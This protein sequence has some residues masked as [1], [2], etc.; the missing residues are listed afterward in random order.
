MKSNNEVIKTNH[1]YKNPF[2][3]SSVGYTSAKLSK[4]MELSDALNT[5]FQKIKG[6][7]SAIHTIKNSL[8]F[9]TSTNPDKPKAYFFIGQPGCGKTECA[10]IIANVLKCGDLSVDASS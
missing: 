4:I 5:A 2:A 10:N 7:D 3:E 6:Q 8:L 1:I 9:S